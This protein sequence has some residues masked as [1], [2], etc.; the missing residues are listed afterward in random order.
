[1][2]TKL[3][4]AAVMLSLSACQSGPKQIDPFD[5]AMNS[6]VSKMFDTEGNPIP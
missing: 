3:I 4:L 2:K 5:A 1:M 6:F